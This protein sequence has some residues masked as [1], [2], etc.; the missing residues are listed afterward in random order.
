ML[1]VARKPSEPVSGDV[2][3]AQPYLGSIE[4]VSS[5]I[6]PVTYVLHNSHELPW[7]LFQALS[8]YINRA[9]LSVRMQIWLPARD[10]KTFL[11]ED[12]NS[13]LSLIEFLVGQ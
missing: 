8:V 10:L 7:Y 11:G 12:L 6:G 9:L 4:M 3:G 2:L 1:A 5:R 13:P